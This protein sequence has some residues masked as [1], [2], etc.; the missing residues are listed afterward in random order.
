MP[1]YM[2]ASFLEYSR[3]SKQYFRDI[4]FQKH[5]PEMAVNACTTRRVVRNIHVQLARHIFRKNG[6]TYI[7]S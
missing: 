2:Y 1:Y 3:V 4:Y 7:C 5:F 6:M